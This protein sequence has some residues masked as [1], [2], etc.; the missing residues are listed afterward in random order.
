MY[1]AYILQ[2]LKITSLIF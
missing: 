2:N 1:R